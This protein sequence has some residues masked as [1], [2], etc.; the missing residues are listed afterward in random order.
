MITEVTIGFASS[1]A[2]AI[3][4]GLQPCASAIRANTSIT[5]QAR[6]LSTIGKSNVERRE[7][8]GVWLSRRYLPDSS[9]P[10]S[11]LQT[12]RPT[13]S[14]SSSG[15]ISRSMSRPATE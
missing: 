3:R 14:A 10:A 1:Q 4:A 5:S 15:P 11:G 2:R 9:P 6:S 12:R 7:P 13:F 8:S